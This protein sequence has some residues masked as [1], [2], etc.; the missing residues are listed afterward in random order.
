MNFCTDFFS[1]HPCYS[2]K[3]EKQICFNFFIS[4][5]T[6]CD[7]S[8]ECGNYANPITEVSPLCQTLSPTG[9]SENGLVHD[10]FQFHQTL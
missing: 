3:S 10:M 2:A 4:V 7:V 1:I 8:C 5:V 9:T 6:S